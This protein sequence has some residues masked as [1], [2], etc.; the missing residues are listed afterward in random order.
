MTV[1]CAKKHPSGTS[2][3]SKSIWGNYSGVSH[4]CRKTY[5]RLSAADWCPRT[6]GLGSASLCGGSPSDRLNTHP[7][8]PE[9]AASVKRHPK[10][11]LIINMLLSAG[12]SADKPFVEL[13]SARITLTTRSCFRDTFRLYPRHAFTGAPLLTKRTYA[14]MMLMADFCLMK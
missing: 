12:L 5:R 10:T 7:L 6:G 11:L 13:W 3:H 14:L 4:K 2:L 9:K 1:I 8:C